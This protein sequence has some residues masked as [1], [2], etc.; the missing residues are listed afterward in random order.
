MNA[1]LTPS[2][3]VIR[4]GIEIDIAHCLALDSDYQSDYVWQMTVREAAKDI[5][6]S[7]H[8]QRLPRPLDARHTPSQAR[9]A[10]AIRRRHCFIVLQETA[11]SHIL[12][13]LSMRVDE[14]CQLA[15]LQDIV[16]D[17]ACRRQS[18]GARLIHVAQ[19]W[20]RENQLHQIIFEIPT[21]NYPCILF[22]KAQGFVFCGFNDHHFPDREIALFFG[23]SI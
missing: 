18:L 3:L 15:Y 9:L 2:Q 19:L 5:Q 6:I 13:Y 22:A 14:S 12:G 4:D 21:T 10:L 11:S 23:M 20:A 7:C 8:E 16:V 1:A 17:K